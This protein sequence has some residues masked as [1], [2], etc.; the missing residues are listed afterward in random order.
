MSVNKHSTARKFMSLL[1]QN[2]FQKA[3]DGAD[4]E[5]LKITDIY[6]VD[7][8]KYRGG[9][10]VDTRVLMCKTEETLK[11]LLCQYNVKNVYFHTD[12]AFTK[13]KVK[14]SD[15]YGDDLGM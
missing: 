1:A 9:N 3:I 13:F 11:D 8:V 5:G 6:E 2:I 7:T 15:C 12:K 4:R 10:T 14:I